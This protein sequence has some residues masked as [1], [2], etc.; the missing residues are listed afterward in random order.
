[1]VVA[2]SANDRPSRRSFLWTG[3]AMLGGAGLL[4][5]CTTSSTASGI[6]STNASSARTTGGAPQQSSSSNLA[7]VLNR[8]KLIVG[9]G[10]GNPP[11]HFND[12]GGALL[13]FD[14]ELA[15]IVANGLFGSDTAVEFVQESAASRIANLLT[16]KVDVVFQFMTVFAARAQQVEFTI[17]Y[18]RE[19]NALMLLANGKYQNHAQLKAAGSAVTV[20]ALQNAGIDSII[21]AALP[22]A[23]VLQLDSVANSIQ[24]VESGRADA[25]QANVSTIGYLQTQQ[26][27]KYLDSGF[28]WLPQTYAAAVKPGD[29]IWLNWLNT[30]LHEAMT[31]V[32]FASYSAAFQKYFAQTLPQPTLGFPMEFEPR[33]N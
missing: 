16:D 6:A 26:P 33:T 11:W 3:G 14:I 32:K 5:A 22:A 28:H 20:S 27:G 1:M 13:G 29:Q 2:Q 23:K 21:H 9:T 4:A 12:S 7:K 10:T 17:P 15:R 8:K 31:G 18:Y 19:G 30:T 25:V 24:A